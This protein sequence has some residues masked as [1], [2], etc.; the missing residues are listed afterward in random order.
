MISFSQLYSLVTLLAPVFTCFAILLI[1][2]LDAWKSARGEWLIKSKA[3]MYFACSLVNWTSLLFYFF[4]PTVFVYLNWFV[5]LTF[6]LVQVYC[7]G[8][9]SKI[10]R[11]DSNEQFSK[12][13]YLLPLLISLTLLAVSLVTPFEEQLQIIK[14][15]GRYP[16]KADR[17]FYLISNSKIVVR[18][19][20]NAVY[21]VLAFYRLYRYRK[22]IGDYSGNEEKN[23]LG[24]LMVYLYLAVGLTPLPIVALLCGSRSFI[25]SSS[26]MTGYN[27]V[28]IFQSVYLCYFILKGKYL[29]MPEEAVS[30]TD[31]AENNVL[32]K[33]LLSR[34]SFDQYMLSAKPYLNSDLKITD[35]VEA[36]GINRTYISAFINAEYQMNFSRYINRCRLDEYS[37]LKENPAHKERNQKELAEMAGFSSYKSLQRFRGKDV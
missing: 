5:Y 6:M 37:H 35:L 30:M 4:Y 14:A 28:F 27:L 24:W 7:Y 3:I 21:V 17:L 12:Y 2:S 19:C 16:Q 22:F 18:S 26:L 31:E 15:Q 29:I 11:I 1:L 32:K 13:H 34:E 9:L 36:L 20:F 33:S 25:I 23:R 10:T 8:F